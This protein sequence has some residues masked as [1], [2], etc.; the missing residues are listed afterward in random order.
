[1]D[2]PTSQFAGIASAGPRTLFTVGTQQSSSPCC[3]LTL[4]EHTSNG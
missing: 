2:L 1:M 3:D 4:A